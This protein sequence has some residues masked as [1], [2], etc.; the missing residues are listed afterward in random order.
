MIVQ[1]DLIGC[2]VDVGGQQGRVR[3]ACVAGQGGL[4]L[5]LQRSDGTL[6]SVDARIYA[7]KMIESPPAGKTTVN[8][9]NVMRSGRI[10]RDGAIVS[11]LTRPRQE[12]PPE[13]P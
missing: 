7:V 12:T 9:T 6:W 11:S 1:T 13:Q 10:L 8:V 2:L 4:T 5:W 3:A